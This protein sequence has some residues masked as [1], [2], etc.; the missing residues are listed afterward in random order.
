MPATC[1]YPFG[2]P[3]CPS[4]PAD[5]ASQS[6]LFGSYRSI[7]SKVTRWPGEIPPTMSDWWASSSSALRQQRIRAWTLSPLNTS[8]IRTCLGLPMQFLLG[9]VL[10]LARISNTKLKKEPDW[11]VFQVSPATR[12]VSPAAGFQAATHRSS[13][14][15]HRVDLR[16]LSRDYQGLQGGCWGPVGAL[17]SFEIGGVS[18][19]GGGS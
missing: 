12:Q 4:C 8:I 14:F 18:F 19:R 6:S 11:K 5:K 15:F 13:S 16:P 3:S 17:G 1:V 2:S 7:S 9:F 10:L